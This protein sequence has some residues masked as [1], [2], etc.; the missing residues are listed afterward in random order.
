[1]QVVHEVQEL[2]DMPEV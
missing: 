1:M 2:Q